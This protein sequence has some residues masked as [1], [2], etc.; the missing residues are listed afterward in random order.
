VEQRCVKYTSEAAVDTIELLGTLGLHEALQ[1]A[2][3][4]AQ[5]RRGRAAFLELAAQH[6]RLLAQPFILSPEMRAGYATKHTSRGEESLWH[7]GLVLAKGVL[8]SGQLLLGLQEDLL[9]LLARCLPLLD[10]L[11]QF[12]QLRLRLLQTLPAQG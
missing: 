1:H 3:A 10:R 9:H 4:A 2:P 7:L 5:C 11:R 12:L 6:P 8:Q